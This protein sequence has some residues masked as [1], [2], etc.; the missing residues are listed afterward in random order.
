VSYR[1]KH[2]KN[3]IQR[4]K[5]KKSFLR[6]PIFYCSFLV[7]FVIGVGIYLWLFFPYFQVENIKL[8]GNEKVSS[9]EIKNVAYQEIY[10]NFLGV[11]GWNLSSKS[12]FLVNPEIIQNKILDKFVLIGTA[13]VDKIFPQTINV[14]IEERK[15]F[16][17]FCKQNN[18]DCFFIDSNGVIFQQ[19]QNISQDVLQNMAV[20][21]QTPENRDVFVGE[22]VIGKN[23]VDAISQIKKSLKENFQ[24]N[25]TEAF[26]SNPLRLDIKTSENWQIYLSLDDIADISS[27]VAKLNSLLLQEITPD[28]RK[29]LQYIDLRFKDRAYYK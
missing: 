12:I 23:I 29:N 7:C 19:V 22:N 20:I 4:I 11:L 28:A 10:K 25:L 14:K 8:F 9:E 5:P 18:Q 26:V 3:K 1:K 6:Q 24:I 13:Q 27:Q 17:I 2:I 21:R 15:P 16:A